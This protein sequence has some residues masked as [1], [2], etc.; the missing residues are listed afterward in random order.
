M[1]CATRYTH[2]VGQA[3]IPIA[4]QARVTAGLNAPPRDAADRD[5]PAST[6]NPIARPSKMV[7]VVPLLVAT[8][9]TT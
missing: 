4:A 1:T 9:S 3:K 5:A 8:F 6:V 7:R 2:S